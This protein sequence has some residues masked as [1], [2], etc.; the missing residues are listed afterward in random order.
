MARAKVG[1]STE[2]PPSAEPSLVDRFPL[3]AH[4]LPGKARL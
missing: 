4:I 3:A 2:P 1:V